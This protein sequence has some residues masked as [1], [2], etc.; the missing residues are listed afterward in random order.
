M[1][2]NI[3]D[4]ASLLM[5]PLPEQWADP[6]KSLQAWLRITINCIRKTDD[7]NL[8]LENHTNKFPK[9]INRKHVVCILNFIITQLRKIVL[10]LSVWSSSCHCLQARIHIAVEIPCR[11]SCLSS[12][13]P[14]ARWQPW[15]HH[16]TYRSTHH[17]AKWIEWPTSNAGSSWSINYFCF[18][19]T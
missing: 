17:Q 1:N 12:L 13:G 6:Q 16:L 15:R 14:R 19:G 8:F 3:G 11:C 10:R 4:Q 7:G 9:E 18:R 2:V 5:S